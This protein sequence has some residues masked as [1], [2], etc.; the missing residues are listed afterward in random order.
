MFIYP[1]DYVTL[2]IKKERKSSIPLFL[3]M[4]IKQTFLYNGEKAKIKEKK[5]KTTE[6][7]LNIRL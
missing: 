7:R 3:Y 4:C 6:Q 5:K 2:L 1:A